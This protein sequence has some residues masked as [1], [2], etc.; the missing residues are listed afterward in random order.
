MNFRH[1]QI[2]AR[3]QKHRELHQRWSRVYFDHARSESWRRALDQ[4]EEEMRENIEKL[5]GLRRGH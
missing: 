4:I 5:K 1:H 2:E 3:K